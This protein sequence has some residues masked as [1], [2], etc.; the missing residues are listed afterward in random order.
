MIKK[1]FI[2]IFI[3]STQF[4]AKAQGIFDLINKSD[5]LLLYM[6]ENKFEAAHNLFD[7]AVKTSLTQETLKNIWTQIHDKFGDYQSIDGAQNRKDG[8]YQVVVLNCTFSK[9]TQPFQ[10]AFN[11]KQKLVGFRILAKSTTEAYKL[12]AYADSTKYTEKNIEIKSGKYSLPGM[13]TTPRTGA[14]FPVV[15]LIHGSGPADMDESVGAN[16]TFK[17]LALG[18]AANGIASIRYVKRTIL[19]PND[20]GG[21]FTVKEEVMDDALAAI[22][23]AKTLPAINTKQIY[24][25]GHSLGGMLAP[26]IAAQNKDIE[27]IILAAAPSGLLAD[28]IAEQNKYFF[29]KS[30]DTTK[31]SKDALS[32]ALTEIN[33]AKFTSLG[34][35]KP[36]SV[37]LGLPAAYWADLNANSQIETAKKLKTKFYVLQGEYD[38][39]VA[40]ANFSNWQTA[41]KNKKNSVFKK[42]PKLNHLFVAVDAKADATQ[43]QKAGNVDIALINDVSNWIKQ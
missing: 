21:A 8:N 13:L 30:G 9:E 37:V 41:L 29:N 22:A 5:S 2:I 38:F 34:N 23:L 6:Q 42:Y 14:N 26:R 4:A 25:F 28:V 16:K 11:D 24:L 12:P 7:D 39:Q 19:Y 15:I 40:D 17:D 31:V 18:L 10:F 36:D 3:C 32:K 33:K 20:F 43:Y 27:G 35:L 1:V